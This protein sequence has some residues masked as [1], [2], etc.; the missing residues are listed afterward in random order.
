MNTQG[1]TT[2]KDVAGRLGLSPSTVSHVCNGRTTTRVSPQTRTRI[3]QAVRE[4]GYRPNLLST[5]LRGGK[6]RVIGLIQPRAVLGEAALAT[7]EQVEGLLRDKGYALLVQHSGGTQP[8]EVD[9]CVDRL[10]DRGVDGI[11]HFQGHTPAG[12]VHLDRAAA[13]GLPVVL[14]GQ[15]SDL[16]L[17]QV[18]MDNSGAARL[19]VEHLAATGRTRLA[20]FND[21]RFLAP[22]RRERDAGFREAH[23]RYFGPVRP[24]QIFSAPA[25][26]ETML[27]G[28]R[29]AREILPRLG[30]FDAIVCRNDRMAL[31]AA[32]ILARAGV[33]IPDD[34][35]LTGFNNEWFT[36]QMLPS[37]TTVDRCIEEAGRLAAQW[38]LERLEGEPAR[39]PDEIHVVRPMLQ[40]RESTGLPPAVRP[41]GAGERSECSGRSRS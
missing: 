1:R 11:L 33:S 14:Y 7:I 3:L 27:N 5:G 25:V 22:S 24:E 26:E 39:A 34:I 41:A 15:H 20:F 31:G 38:L 16:A 21:E 18:V 12:S 32:Q 6:S 8:R 10:L 35:A 19:I 28:Q 30:E 2:L 40:V 9:A 36:T 13:S 37:L 4:T 23:E 17:P 29:H